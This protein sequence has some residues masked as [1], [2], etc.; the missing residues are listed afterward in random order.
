MKSKEKK[1]YSSFSKLFGIC[2]ISLA[3][4][5]VFA[6][7]I[8]ASTEIQSTSF[9]VENYNLIEEYSSKISKSITYYG[10]LDTSDEKTVSISVAEK[11]NVHRT[12]LFELQSHPDV[13]SRLIENE[14]KA[15]YSRAEAIGRLAWIYY[16]NLPS[17]AGDDAIARID[18]KYLAFEREICAGTDSAVIDAQANVICTELNRAVYAEKIKGLAAPGDSI[19]TAALIAGAVNSLEKASAPDLF[20]DNFKKIFEKVRTDVALQRARDSVTSEL[21]EL[22]SILCPNESFSSNE[23]VTLFVY[24]AKN[25]ETIPQINKAL[26]DTVLQ[27]TQNK[28][29]GNYS[30]IYI[31]T[32]NER[33]AE[34]SNRASNEGVGTSILSIFENYSLDYQKSLSK[35]RINE[36]LFAGTEDDEVLKK[37]ELAFNS[38]GGSIDRCQ[39]IS[40][41]AFETKCAEYVRLVFDEISSAKEKLS[42]FLGSYDTSAFE[43]RLEAIRDSSFESLFEKKNGQT[44]FETECKS[45]LQNAKSNA[46]AVLNESRAER[47]L[48]DNKE[49][50]QK[51]KE[52]IK[53]S[54]ELSLRSAITEYT[55]LEDTVQSALRSQIENIAEKYNILT[56][57]KIR[58]LLSDD[59]LYLDLSELFCNEVKNLSASNIDVFYNSCDKIYS[60]SEVLRDAILY[61]RQIS[62][63]E[64]YPKFSDTEKQDLLNVCEKAA[65]KLQQINPSDLLDFSEKLNEV[66]QSSAISMDRINECARIRISA[67]NSQNPA[68]QA[69]VAEAGAKIKASNNKAEMMAISEKMI[70]KINRE[71]TREEIAKRSHELKLKIKQMNFLSEEEKESISNS[72][73]SA[74]SSAYNDAGVAENLTV[75]NFVWNTFVEKLDSISTEANSTDLT[76]AVERYNELSEKDNSTFKSKLNAMAHLNEEHLAEFYNSSTQLLAQF[77]AEIALCTSSSSIAEEYSK[78]LEQLYSLEVSANIENVDNYKKTIKSK[79]ETLKASK[80]NYSVENYNKLEQEIAKAIQALQSCQSITECNDL[81]E[82][83]ASNAKNIPNLLDDAKSDAREKLD[84]AIRV[85]RANISSYSEENTLRLESLYSEAIKKIANYQ[86]IDDIPALKEHLQ[87]ILIAMSS[88]RKDILFSSNDASAITQQAPKYPANYNFSNGYWGCI[89]SAD[90]ISSNAVFTVNNAS[91][92]Y[93]TGKIQALIRKAARGNNFISETAIPAQTLKALKKCVVSLGVDI[94]LSSIA[95]TSGKYNVRML[96]PDSLAGENILGIVF[97]DKDGNAEFYNIQKDGCLIS[98]DISHFS[99]YYIV[100]ESTTNL[101][102]FITFLTVTFILEFVALLLIAAIHVARKRKEKNMPPLLRSLILSPIFPFGALRVQP[103]NGVSLCV[104]LG[105]GVLALGCGIAFLAKLELKALKLARSK[106]PAEFVDNSTDIECSTNFEGSKK[107]NSKQKIPVLC[108]AKVDFLPSADDEADFFSEEEHESKKEDSEAN[109]PL[110]RKAEVNLDAIAQAFEEGAL[111]N[112]ETLKQKRLVGKRTEYVKILARGSLTKPFVIEAHDFSRAAEDMLKSVG[113]EA[114]RIK[115]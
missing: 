64:I 30:A 18:G 43:A 104:L 32:L 17:I 50:L 38:N 103:N 33:V 29:K 23:A 56:C 80:D 57:Q 115:Y 92:S 12:A 11:I 35:D 28:I 75:L 52:S 49:I 74:H 22:F 8:A 102:P 46:T 53:A 100:S 91:G 67:R 82:K 34:A 98:F 44:N 10:E 7:T 89:Y 42:I 107:L 31:G 69:L 71:L 40:S 90:G 1:R 58:T 109:V 15:A 112:L 66:S 72:I 59:S 2:V 54:D 9:I 94:S 3:L 13:S 27:L 73:K 62:A 111:V 26:C 84:S 65:E 6:P 95:D 108:S 101:T 83:A 20:G 60:K 5:F 37:I 70:F 4:S 61:Y 86:S 93:D 85:Y 25:A 114:I 14:I 48:L 96:L 19:D 113:G 81:F 79:L 47:F 78:Y 110:H 16:H 99:T 55:R 76:R 41:L 63:S 68:V 106:K 45:I 97:V 39:S 87:S 77:K 21:N 88:I 36:L 24:N 105:I 51:P